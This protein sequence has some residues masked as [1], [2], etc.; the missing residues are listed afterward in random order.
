MMDMRESS[1]I[2][3]AIQCLLIQPK[4][5]VMNLGGGDGQ[6][7]SVCFFGLREYA[8]LILAKTSVGSIA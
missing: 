5:P 7:D 8:D 1:S 4:K 3:T 2:M 6:L